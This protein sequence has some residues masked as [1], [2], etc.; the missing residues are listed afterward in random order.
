MI[1]AST[2]LEE[3]NDGGGIAIN[4]DPE[5][6]DFTIVTSTGQEI[7]IDLGTTFDDDDEIDDEAVE[8]VGELLTRVNAALTDELGAGQVVMSIRADGKGFE[9]TDNMGG[10]GNV[11]VVGAGPG[12]TPGQPIVVD[13]EAAAVGEP[14]RH[15]RRQLRVTAEE[16]E[17]AEQRVPHRKGGQRV[18]LHGGGGEP[19]HGG[20]IGHRAYE[21][22]PAMAHRLR[23][24]R[25]RRRRHAGDERH[26]RRDRQQVA[27]RKIGGRLRDDALRA[28]DEGP[29]HRGH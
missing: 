2:E 6:P 3:L 18:R 26:H 7:D 1:D 9:I 12:G 13:G 5:S 21:R 19:V 11:E 29:E 25:E 28:A 14:A 17:A 8:N 24:A 4:E 16:P 22:E 20:R 15:E 23:S 10:G 27:H